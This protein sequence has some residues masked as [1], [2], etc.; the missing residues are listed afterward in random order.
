[1]R[2]KCT[3]CTENRDHWPRPTT[4]LAQTLSRGYCRRR[5]RASPIRG[6]RSRTWGSI[7]CGR[8]CWLGVRPLRA[9]HTHTRMAVMNFQIGEESLARDLIIIKLEGEVDL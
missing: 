1:M 6:G 3:F 2:A 9:C 8:N 7:A 4:R 5:P